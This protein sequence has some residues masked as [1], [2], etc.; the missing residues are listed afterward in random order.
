M[1]VVEFE[2]LYFA[3]VC[4]VFLFAY[5]VAVQSLLYPNSEDK[6]WDILYRIFY[7]PYLTMFQQ[8]HI[9][10]LQ[11]MP[12]HVRQQQRI[13]TKTRVVINGNIVFALIVLPICFSS[14]KVLNTFSKPSISISVANTCFSLLA[15]VAD[16]LFW[17]RPY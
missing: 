11:G 15:S 5:G 3:M 17:V 7:Q 1:Q 6:W 9:D 2:L 12:F 13:I 14:A 10:E 16:F 8:F 4:L